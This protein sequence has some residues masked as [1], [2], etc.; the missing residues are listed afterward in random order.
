MNIADIQ[1]VMSSRD[2]S[3]IINYEHMHTALSQG[4]GLYASI[5]GHIYAGHRAATE[6]VVVLSSIGDHALLAV[7][8]SEK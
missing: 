2:I 3:S 5:V 1:K 4:R 7:D 8:M 6:T